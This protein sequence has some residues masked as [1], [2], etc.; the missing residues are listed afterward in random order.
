[1]FCFLDEMKNFARQ[2][3]DPVFQFTSLLFLIILHFALVVTTIVGLS[4]G[5]W[6][7]GVA[8]GGSVFLLCYLFLAVLWFA[9]KR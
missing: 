1:M 2:W 4:F 8:S 9:S 6:I 3:V 5:S 7:I